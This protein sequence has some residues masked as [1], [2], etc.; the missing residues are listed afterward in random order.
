MLERLLIVLDTWTSSPRVME[1]LLGDLHVF[2]TRHGFELDGQTIGASESRSFVAKAS[3]SGRSVQQP[4]QGVF[5]LVEPVVDE[6]K[7]H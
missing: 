4:V 5:I 1:L 3:F 7:S 6:L 2:C